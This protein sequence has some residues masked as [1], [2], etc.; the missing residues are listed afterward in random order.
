L[1]NENRRDDALDLAGFYRE[2]QKEDLDKM[3]RPDMPDSYYPG[4]HLP[5]KILKKIYK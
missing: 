4:S 2:N 3:F 1:R 5:E